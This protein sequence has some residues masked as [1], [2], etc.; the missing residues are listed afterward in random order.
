MPV[1]APAI[2]I[3]AAW[4]TGLG[5]L[6]LAFNVRQW[7]VFYAEPR[8]AVLHF[9]ALF[10]VAAWA[11]DR[12]VSRRGGRAPGAGWSYGRLAAWAARAP[13][14]WGVLAAA[15]FAG[16][17]ALSTLAS[18]LPWVS[19]WGRDFND[20]SNELYSLLSLMVIFFAIALRLRSRA[21][22]RRV[23]YV[24]VGA[25]A[26][27]SAYG[28]A[29]HFG[30]HAL[31][32]GAGDA[33]VFAS[34]GNPI[35]FGSYL[36]MSIM[37]TLAVALDAPM[38]GRGRWLIVAAGLAGLQVAALWFTGSRG[39][40]LGF[41][42]GS[43]AFFVI[44]W[45]W[46]DRRLL[47]R[48]GGVLLAGV[49]IAAVVALLPADTREGGRGVSALGGALAEAGALGTEGTAMSGSRGAI[50]GGALRLSRTWEREPEEA[51]VVR[52]LRPALG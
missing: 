24:L 35:F 18:P 5:L 22:A 31:G 12:A 32:P 17:A 20:L 52:L 30:W 14:R 51:R 9:V 45:L 11:L 50:W 38:R 34:F 2:A 27:T 4:L 33:R 41:A 36:V 44:G 25:G 3:E 6:P 47:L 7:V 43:A 16:A 42:S 15:G 39:P 37:A 49:A 1:T 10:I 13:G 21:Q 29:Q 26:L 40:W 28:V 23:V 46:L 8:Y 48:A 19:L